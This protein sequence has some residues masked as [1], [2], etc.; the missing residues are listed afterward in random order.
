MTN[1]R[2]AHTQI[3][4]IAIIMTV[5]TVTLTVI[6]FPRMSRNSAT[7]RARACET[8]IAMINTQL[9]VYYSE[10]NTWP[11]ELT[12]ITKNINYFPKGEPVCPSGGKYSINN[13][14]HR[15]SCNIHRE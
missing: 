2:N 4:T 12:D 8:N 10:N 3:E 7:A 1:K 11:A 5:V 13:S 9:E 6:A 14:T 15:V